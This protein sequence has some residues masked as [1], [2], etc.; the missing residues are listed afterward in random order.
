M[1]DTLIKR[2]TDT[3]IR[4]QDMQQKKSERKHIQIKTSDKC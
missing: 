2:R 1:F 4:E 3:S